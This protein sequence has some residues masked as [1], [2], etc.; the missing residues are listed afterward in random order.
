MSNCILG[1]GILDETCENTNII[2]E[3][4]IPILCMGLK[5]MV[6]AA[7]NEGILVSNKEQSSYIKPFVD[8]IDQ[9]IMFAEKS[10]GYYRVIDY[11]SNSITVKVT[12]HR[13][14]NMN[15]HSHEYRDEVWTVVSGEGTAV[16]DSKKV[17]LRPGVVVNL[18]CFCRHTV[19]AKT[20]LEIIEIQMGEGITVHDKKKYEYDYNNIINEWGRN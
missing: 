9:Q 1:K 4:N 18:P 13:N 16:I 5:D 2:N 7:S 17:A 11:T 19:I 6:V 8:S 12:L 15:Y 20:K 3:L 14:C 10:W